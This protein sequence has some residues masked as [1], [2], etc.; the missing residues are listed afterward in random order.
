MHVYLYDFP[1]KKQCENHIIGFEL[2]GLRVIDNFL[3]EEEEIGLIDRID[4]SPWLLSQ[5]GRS[6]QVYIFPHSSPLK[7]ILLSYLLLILTGL[8]S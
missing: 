5:S 3:T 7:G 6:K 1:D 2:D 8:W 4:E